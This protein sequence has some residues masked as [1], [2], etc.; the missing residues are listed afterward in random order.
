VN[1]NAPYF[2]YASDQT[3]GTFV[4]SL[5][6]TNYASGL[7]IGGGS[8]NLLWKGTRVAT[9]ADIPSLSN[10]STLANTIK[11]LS[12]SGKTITYT[13]GDGTTGTLTTQDTVYSLP[14]AGSTLGGVKSGGDVTI[15]SGTIT[16]NTVKSNAAMGNVNYPI[17]VM[18]TNAAG[19]GDALYKNSNFTYNPNTGTINAAVLPYAVKSTSS[20][21]T[22]GTKGAV[23]IRVY[24]GN[25]YIYTS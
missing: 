21:T 4:W 12:I 23:R 15:S 14:T 25:L 3:D 24:G 6:G 5:K 20:T 1:S 13:K 17:A 19:T 22:A 16:V 7:A 11:A 8:G 9:T 10:Y 2:G 18:S